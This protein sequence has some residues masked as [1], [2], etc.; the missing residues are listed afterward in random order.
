ML[1]A[2]ALGV[3][4]HRGDAAAVLALEPVVELEPL[5]DLVE[6]A[7]LGLERLGVAAQLRPEVLG[8]EPQGGQPL[9]ERVQLG[10]RA[11]DRLREPLGVGEQAATPT[12]PAASPL[13][14]IASAPA[15]AAASRP[16]SW[17][18]RSRSAASASSSSSV[19]SSA[20]ISSISNASRSRSRSRAP[21]RSRSSASVALELAHARVGGGERRAHVEVLAPA[22]AVEQLELRRGEREPPV[23]VLAEERDQP[24]AERLQVGRR[25]GAALDERRCVPSR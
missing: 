10:I 2:A 14:A 24:A 17:R 8:L 1:L 13:G 15:P 16:S 20:S 18:S 21:A 3:R 5:L 19:G 23:L 25:G 11:R 7:G 4:E 6:P 12:P 22:E 9:G